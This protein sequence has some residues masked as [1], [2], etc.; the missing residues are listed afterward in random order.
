MEKK[1]SLNNYEMDYVAITSDE[2]L[3]T[4]INN[5]NYRININYNY[6]GIKSGLSYDNHEDLSFWEY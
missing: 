4:T 2:N 1:L 5:A 6:F 3:D